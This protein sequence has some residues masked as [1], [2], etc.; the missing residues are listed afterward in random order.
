VD[1]GN[2]GKGGEKT[3]G[4]DPEKG[5]VCSALITRGKTSTTSE[6]N[7]KKRRTRVFKREN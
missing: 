3:E 4:G 1:K 2:S 7:L 5:Q 6:E